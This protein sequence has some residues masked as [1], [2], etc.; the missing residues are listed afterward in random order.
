[1]I[2]FH[3]DVPVCGQG[4]MLCGSWFLK[5]FRNAIQGPSLFPFMSAISTDMSLAGEIVCGCSAHAREGGREESQLKMNH[6]SK[7]KGPVEGR[8]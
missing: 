3:A 8:E 5:V 7:V 2:T 4:S 6:P 1:M